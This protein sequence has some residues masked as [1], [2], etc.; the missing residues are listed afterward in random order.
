M[1]LSHR[2]VLLQAFSHIHQAEQQENETE[3]SRERSER[4]TG[5]GGEKAVQ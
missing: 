4:V 5:I 2:K 1:M 3:R